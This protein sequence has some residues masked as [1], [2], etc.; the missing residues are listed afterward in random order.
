M[1]FNSKPY[2][3]QPL[4]SV[5]KI[6]MSN[7]KDR[8]LCVHA[9]GST[10]MEPPLNESLKQVQNLSKEDIKS[11]TRIF[12]LTDGQPT[13]LED[14]KLESIAKE[15]TNSKIYITWLG[16]GIDFNLSLVDRLTKVKANNYY[17]VKTAHQFKKLLDEEFDYVASADIFDAVVKYSG[18]GFTVER[19][20]GSPG[21]EI[22]KEGVLFQMSSGFPSLKENLNSTKGGIILIKLKRVE[23]GN[24]VMNFLVTYTDKNGV[25]YEHKETF[26]FPKH[27][28][29]SADSFSGSAARKGVL[30]VR[31]VNFIKNFLLDECKPNSVDKRTSKQV[32]IS[33]PS[34][35]EDQ[36]K[37][38]K[39]R[40]IPNE[41]KELFNIFIKYFLIEAD[42]LGDEGLMKLVENAEQIVGYKPKKEDVPV[43]TGLRR[44]FV[45]M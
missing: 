35:L 44:V 5:A 2:V 37:S 41:Y 11:E 25:A 7:L 30:L 17:S 33:V 28:V 9:E 16:I 43:P 40:E 34:L 27:D 29:E 45:P 4:Q 15:L 12:Y 39:K 38:G 23:N 14:K 6:D 1:T 22:P 8:I 19:V 21:F 18:G 24:P 13:S 32:G 36:T 26:E 10:V 42:T 3:I 31:Y 20:Y